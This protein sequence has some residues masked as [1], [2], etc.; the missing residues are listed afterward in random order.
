MY[1]KGLRLLLLLLGIALVGKGWHWAKDGFN[2][3]RTRFA[4]PLVAKEEEDIPLEVRS[5]LLQPFFYLSRGHQCYAFESKDGNYVLKLPRVDRYRL[6]FWLRSCR[7]SFLDRQREEI[8]FDRQKRFHFLMN[9]FQIAFN[10]MRKET[11]LLYLHFHNSSSFRQSLALVDR[12]GR[13]Y[14]LDLDRIPFLLQRKKAL[15]MPLL[16]QSLQNRDRAEAEK[17]LDAFLRIVAIRAK[18][19]IFN[20]DPSFLR[21]FGFEEGEGMQI[22]VGSFYRD[23]SQDQEVSFAPSFRQTTQHVQEWLFSIDPEVAKWFARRVEEIVQ[24]Q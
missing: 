8:S 16:E 20:K 2:I 21:N 15:M 23:P 17:I 12:I 10:E 24:T 6:P 5:A 14:R 3:E 1:R 19:G 9:S 13:A 18:K 7:F 4:L 22:D 11:A